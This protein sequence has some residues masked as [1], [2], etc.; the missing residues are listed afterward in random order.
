MDVETIKSKLKS[1][2]LILADADRLKIRSAAYSKFRLVFDSEEIY[3]GF[4]TCTTC[5]KLIKHD[6]HLSGTTHLS[7]H[8]ATHAS[9]KN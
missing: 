5:K 8:A 6:I 2:E 1:G 9:S 7:R 3:V 4:V